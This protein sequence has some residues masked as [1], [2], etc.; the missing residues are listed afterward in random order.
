VRFEYKQLYFGENV[1]DL[2]RASTE[3][4]KL[5]ADGWKLVHFAAAHSNYLIYVFERAL[6]SSE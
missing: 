3:I 5:G 2:N 4:N 6:S 1:Q